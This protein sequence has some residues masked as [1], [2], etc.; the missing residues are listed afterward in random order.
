M[1]IKFQYKY[2]ESEKE[3]AYIKMKTHEIHSLLPKMP[4]SRVPGEDYFTIGDILLDIRSRIMPKILFYAWLESEVNMSK[5][6]A[7]KYMKIVRVF[8]EKYTAVKHVPYT[9][10][11]ELTYPS[12]PPS[13]IAGIEDGGYV[14]SLV[15]CQ[16]MRA[17]RE[18]SRDAILQDI[19]DQANALTSTPQPKKMMPESPVLISTPQI[20]AHY[21]HQE[22][23]LEIEALREDVKWLRVQCSKAEQERDALIDSIRKL[24][25]K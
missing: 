7:A 1:S 6:V 24:V 17:E 12:Y 21:D 25:V 11:H 15:R 5:S 3:R 10:L 18:I 16:E 9:T 8:S 22:P 20:K 13:I 23:Y 4:G 19:Y 2:I 14:P